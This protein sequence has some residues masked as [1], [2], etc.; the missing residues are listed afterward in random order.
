MKI[1][2]RYSR[3]LPHI[4]PLNGIFNI[5]FRLAD[6]L[7]ISAIKRLRE[8]RAEELKLFK[9][10]ESTMPPFE[11]LRQKARIYDRYFGKYDQLLNNPQS[12]PTFLKN[13]D[14]A[15]ITKSA[16]HFWDGKKFRLICYCIMPNHVHLMLDSCQ[17]QLYKILG[18]IKQYSAT[19]ANLQL[20]RTGQAF[21][22][23]ESY[24]NLIRTERDLTT[25]LNYILRNPVDARWV[26]HWEE[27]PHTYLNPEMTEYVTPASSRPRPSDF[28]S[29][30]TK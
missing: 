19:Q 13:Q 26:N 30:K 4:Q 15:E 20:K 22:H 23:R 10:R 3:S 7:P 17:D 29:D 24:D 12:G 14:I 1:K 8:E 18:S 21:W 27:W 5:C 28:Q 9:A 2:D 16:I 6:S 11:A 25:K